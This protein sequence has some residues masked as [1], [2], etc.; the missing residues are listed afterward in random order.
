MRKFFVLLLMVLL[1]TSALFAQKTYLGLDATLNYSD[2]ELE[3]A[4]SESKSKATGWGIKLSSATFF[5]S[6]NHGIYESLYLLN[7]GIHE[8]ADGVT[9]NY[10]DFDTMSI[11]DL[12]S[13]D[14]RYAYKFEGQNGLSTIL[15]VGGFF[16]YSEYSENG[17]KFEGTMLGLRT[18]A[19]LL[20]PIMSNKNILL[21]L[22][23]DISI[24]LSAD[25]EINGY[26]FDI[27]VSGFDVEGSVGLV[28]SF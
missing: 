1:A 18:G 13:F 24:P 7:H 23:A 20:T 27:D 28:Y 16:E 22:G 6:T 12:F 5:G 4:G 2:L 14:I 25:Y 21:S 10:D 3:F 19:K 17:V 9:L 26:D 8:K 15:S 11:T